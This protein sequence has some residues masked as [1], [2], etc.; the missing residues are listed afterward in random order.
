MVQMSRSRCRHQWVLA[1]GPWP[2]HTPDYRKIAGGNRAVVDVRCRTCLVHREHN[3]FCPGEW[4]STK[5]NAAME[6]AKIWWK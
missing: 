5:I 3:I 6:E 2:L 1:A 4:D